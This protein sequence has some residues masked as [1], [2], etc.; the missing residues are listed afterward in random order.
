MDDDV[1]VMFEC[2][3]GFLSDGD[4][5][6]TCRIWTDPVD[7]IEDEGGG[8]L[9]ELIEAV[10]GLMADAMSIW[11]YPMTLEFRSWAGCRSI[12]PCSLGNGL[13]GGN[14]AVVQ[15]L[16]AQV[17]FKAGDGMCQVWAERSVA[18]RSE[19]SRI[20][21][22]LCFLKDADEVEDPENGA[23][24]FKEAVGIMEDMNDRRV[25]LALADILFSS[26]FADIDDKAVLNHLK[27]ATAGGDSKEMCAAIL[28]HLEYYVV[29]LEGMGPKTRFLSR[30]GEASFLGR[31]VRTEYPSLSWSAVPKWTLLM[32]VICTR[33][34]G[35][36]DY[37]ELRD[38]SCGFEN[39]VFV[40]VPT[41]FR[42]GMPDAPCPSCSNSRV[43]DG[44]RR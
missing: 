9:E 39:D 19:R 27:M 15:E 41:V 5:V 17:L 40:S 23:R 22:A 13:G 38:D 10:S 29:S 18:D 43:R 12:S 11:M 44:V 26:R 8:D 35:L 31:S 16:L 6:A 14:L 28:L 7:S 20:M 30:S 33:K 24:S 2:V 4:M 42:R 21:L 25:H 1:Y 3:C 36:T 32:R 37:R 34:D